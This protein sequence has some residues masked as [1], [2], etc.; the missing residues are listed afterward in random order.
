[1]RVSFMA[2]RM[3]EVAGV[4]CA[5]KSEILD[6]GGVGTGKERLKCAGFANPDAAFL[7]SSGKH[8]EHRR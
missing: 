4:N 5:E 2:V 1:M 3:N 7:L 8:P 6:R